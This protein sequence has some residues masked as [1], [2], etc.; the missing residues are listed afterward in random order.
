MPLLWDEASLV[1]LHVTQIPL[2]ACMVLPVRQLNTSVRLKYCIVLKCLF[3]R[4]SLALR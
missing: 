2:I 3:N 4:R 1:V